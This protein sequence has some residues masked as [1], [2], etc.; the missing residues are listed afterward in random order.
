MAISKNK[1]TRHSI[2]NNIDYKANIMKIIYAFKL[3][4]YTA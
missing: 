1:C 3:K 4:G 2:K